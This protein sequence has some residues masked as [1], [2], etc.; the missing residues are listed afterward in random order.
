MKP[1]EIARQIRTNLM[2]QREKLRDYLKVLEFQKEDIVEED[3]DKLIEHIRLESEVIDELNSLKKIMTPLEE[4]YMASPYKKETD[5]FTLKDT[6]QN[7]S[8]RVT[9]ISDDN[10]KLLDDIIEKQKLK[11]KNVS[12]RKGFTNTVYAT[13]QP[14]LLD[15]RG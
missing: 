6:I 2:K 9:G 8:Q 13:S 7:L 11:L 15:V 10:K 1:D 4:M 5:L 12:R 14:N 3:A